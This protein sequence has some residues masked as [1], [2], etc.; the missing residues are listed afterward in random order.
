MSRRQILITSILIGVIAI[1]STIG[2]FRHAHG[3]RPS[4]LAGP[5]NVEKGDQP[6]APTSEAS[7]ASQFSGKFED[8]LWARLPPEVAALHY[9]H[10]GFAWILKQLGANDELI[11]RLVDGHLVE[12]ITELK[13]RARAG[14]PTAI[15][16]LGEIAHQRCELGRDEATLTSYEA[17]E[18]NQSRTLP[19]PDAE[20]LVGA[21]RADV[22]FDKQVAAMCRELI[23]PDQVESWVEARATQGDGA[24]LWL[25]SDLSNNMTDSQQRLRDAAGAGFPEAQFELAWVIIAGQKGAAGIGVDAANVGDLLR[26]SADALPR[27]EMQLALCEYHGCPGVPID[28]D[29]ALTHAREAA[30][31]G[32]IDGIIDIGPH[33]PAGQIN[34]DEVT[35]WSIIHASLALQGCE[36]NGFS[37]REMKN[38]TAVL[39]SPNITDNARQLANQYWQQFG[40][41]IR[42]NLSCDS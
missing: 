8:S 36:S 25:M 4:G 9:R 16:V 18:T 38:N 20:W 21:L 34:P 12:A 29:T 42:T 14:N 27:S 1:L 22:A 11:T 2:W 28:V 19:G 3:G 40:T 31:R 30:Q 41:Q 35:A 23:N 24:S 5:V 10:T 33:L 7:R 26:Q 39:S 37:V 32:S 13:Q 6:I 17:R 15:N